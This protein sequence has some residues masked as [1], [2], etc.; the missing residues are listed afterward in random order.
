[1][2]VSVCGANFIKLEEGFR[3]RPYLCSAGVATIGYG[4]TRY[5]DGRK[6]TLAD[7]PINKD[8]AEQLFYT[9]LMRFETDVTSLLCVPVT[10]NMFDALV[11]F[12]YNVGSDIDADDKAEGLGDSTLLKKLNR[13]DYPGAADEFLK[14]N[15]SK[16]KVVDGLTARRKRERDIFLES[17]A[18]SF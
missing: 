1:M 8:A 17:Y 7:R 15:K 5:A 6:V 11:S 13:K 14:W 16:G 3:A 10:Q 18:E 12:A 9:M 4:S 2:R